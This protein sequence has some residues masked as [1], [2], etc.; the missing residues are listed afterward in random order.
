MNWLTLHMLLFACDEPDP[1]ILQS[2]AYAQDMT[3]LIKQSEQIEGHF[4]NLA[5]KMTSST[6]SADQVAATLKDDVLADSA[7]LLQAAAAVQTES[8]Q[9]STLHDTLEDAWTQRQAAWQ[10]ALEAW[11]ESDPALLTQ[12]IAARKISRDAEERY[13]FDVNAVLRPYGHQLQLYP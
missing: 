3:P 6:V 9:L 5:G 11:E 13:I 10:Q 7:E 2:Q 8:E 4:L 12:S 1:M